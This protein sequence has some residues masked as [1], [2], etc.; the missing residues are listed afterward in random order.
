MAHPGRLILLICFC[1]FSAI[2]CAQLATVSSAAADAPAQPE[3]DAPSR[4]DTLSRYRLSTGDVISITVY[5]E[6][7]MTKGKIRLTDAG[8]ISYPVLGEIEVRGKTVGDLEKILT[9]GLR[10]RYLVNP[11]VAVTIDEYRPYFINGQVGNNGSFPFQPG[12]TVRKAVSIAGG[13]KERA[14]MSKITIVR[15]GD[16]SNTQVKVDLNAPV[17]P[18]DIITVGES[19]F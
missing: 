19:F 18:G 6:D 16:A 3:T 12:L 7:D 5:G 2:S 11:R 17:Q 13:F 1:L 9:D 15:D 14:S 10:G 4:S 8:T